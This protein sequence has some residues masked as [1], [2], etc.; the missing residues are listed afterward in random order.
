MVLGLPF[1]KVSKIVD[2]LVVFNVVFLLIDFALVYFVSRDIERLYDEVGLGT[3]Y[4]IGVYFFGLRTVIVVAVTLAAKVRF[5]AAER[6]KHITMFDRWMLKIAFWL[7]LGGSLAVLETFVETVIMLVSLLELD[8][9]RLL[10]NRFFA[11]R[12]G[13]WG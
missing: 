6:Q 1:R 8:R 9:R 2:F 5:W 12:T 7:L 4:G 11:S 3:N 13:L 10:Q